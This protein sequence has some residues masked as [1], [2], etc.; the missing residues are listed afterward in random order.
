MCSRTLPD[1][2]VQAAEDV[3]KGVEGAT[4]VP[5]D[6][7]S[8]KAAVV[9]AVVAWVDGAIAKDRKVTALKT[10]QVG[11]EFEASAVR[12]LERTRGRAGGDVFLVLVR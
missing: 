5:A 4:L 2:C 12:R 10:L 8:N 9:D 3:E 11:F 6:D 7:G 1:W